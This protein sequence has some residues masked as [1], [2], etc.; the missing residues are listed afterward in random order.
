MDSTWDAE[1]V[2]DAL[3]VL[4]DLPQWRLSQARWR[5]VGAVLD[6]MR[7]A[8]DAGDDDSLRDLTSD[9]ELLGPVRA[10][11]IGTRSGDEEPDPTIID[12][13]NRLVHDLGTAAPRP[14]PDQNRAPGGDGA[15]RSAR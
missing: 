3:D 9:L 10:N 7:Q 5:Q 11:R 1:T 6:R 15:D 8:V 13:Q 4:T 2:A 12:R 14:A